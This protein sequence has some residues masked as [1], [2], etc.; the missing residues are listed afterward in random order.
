MKARVANNRFFTDRYYVSPNVF[1]IID[2]S[3]LLQMQ[4]RKHLVELNLLSD[5]EIKEIDNLVDLF[6]NG[7]TIGSLLKIKGV[8]LFVVKG[9]LAKIEN[10]AI[11]NIFNAIVLS[12]GVKSLNSLVSLAEI[13]GTKYD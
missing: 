9:A 8:D 3:Y 11:S 6:K 7:K 5:K 4:Y 13:I 2:S 1:E 10:N 12:D